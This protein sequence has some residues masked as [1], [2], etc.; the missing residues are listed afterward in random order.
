MDAAT[1]QAI[2]GIFLP[3]AIDTRYVFRFL[4]SRRRDL[5]HQ[6]KGGAQPNISNAIVRETSISLAPSAEQHRIADAIEEQFTRLDSGVAA[7]KRV[8][9]N[10]KRYKAAVLKTAC[11]GKLTEKW[12]QENPDV[13][14]ASDLLKRILI[15]RRRKWEEAEL[16]KMIAK[17]KPPKDDKWKEKYKEPAQPRMERLPPLPRN[18]SWVTAEQLTPHDRSASYGVL[19]PGPDVDGGIEFI[20]VCDI[21]DGRILRDQ[22]KHIAPEIAGHYPR[23][24]LHGGEVLVTLVGTIGRSAVVPEELAGANTARAVGVIP[25]GDAFMPEFVEIC[26]RRPSKAEELTRKSHEVARKTLNLEDV[27]AT[28]LPL[29]PREEQEAIV[30]TVDDALSITRAAEVAI[31][32]QIS[33]SRNLRQAILRRAFEGK[34][35]EQDPDDEPASVLLERIGDERA[36]RKEADRGRRVRSAR[37]NR[38]AARSPQPLLF[39]DSAR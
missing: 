32:K 21:R 6:A 39:E 19:Q 33:R 20:R 4:E 29:P 23:T 31:S 28:C 38:R 36:K 13:E 12:R 17:G 16:A 5:I 24:K 15:Q 27:R 10:L 14:P 7:L 8:E 3:E 25:I 34:L 1:N 30:E 26:F 2:C 9:A 37:G 11:E 35:V 22:L 18:W